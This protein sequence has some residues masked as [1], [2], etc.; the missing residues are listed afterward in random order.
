MNVPSSCRRFRRCGLPG[1]CGFG[2]LIAVLLCI[3]AVCHAL[4]QSPPFDFDKIVFITR[5][6]C[7]SNHY[8]TD[9][10]NGGFFPEGNLCVL[11]LKT[12]KVGEIV[13]R[14]TGGMFGRFDLSFDATKVVF[15]WKK[16]V[17]EGYRIYEC[18]IDGGHLHQLTVPPPEEPALIAR[19]RRGYHHGTDDMDPCYLPD[20]GI[21][22]IST[23]CQYGI[24]CDGP[25]IF[26][27]T[28]LYRMD[29]NG[30]NLE[31]LTN[32]SVSEATPAVTNDGRIL[33]TRWEYVDK[34]AVSVKCLWA[35]NPDGT[36]S[37]EI[38][39]A[40]IALPPT[41][42]QGRPIPG[43]NNLFVVMGT[44]HCPQNAVGTVIR[45]DAS[46]NT[47]TREPMTYMTPDVDVRAEG[48]FWFDAASKWGPRLFKDPYPLSESRFL[49][50]LNPSGNALE[51]TNWGLYA[52]DESGNATVIYRDERTGCFM[53]IPLRPRT[54][55]PVLPSGRDPELAAKNLAACLVQDVYQGMDGIQ[56]GQAKYLRINEQAPRP[57]S[58]RRTWDERAYDQQH[59]CISKDAS[60]GLKVQHG[61]VP[62]EA[63]GSA[64]F[65]VPA[66]KN[67]YFQVLDA[68]FME[69]QRERTYVNYRPGERRSC[70]GCHE[71]P[72]RVP[73]Q[74]NGVR[75]ALKRSP[76]LP[77]PQPGE[78]TGA[79]P[80]HYPTDV[81]PVW[82]KHCIECHSGKTPKGNLDLSGEITEW[83]NKSYESLMPERRKLPLHDP[84]LLGIIIGENHP[85]TGNVKYLPPKSL[86]SHTSVLVAM[87][88]GGSVQ[89]TNPADAVRA[90][91]LA[92]KHKQIKLTPEELVRITTW[93]EANGQYYGSYYGKR[94]SKFTGDPDFRPVP[95]FQEATRQR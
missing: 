32:S 75:L 82:D 6:N 88:S 1:R 28:V 94:L 10:I 64:Y 76:S 95:T 12:G 48:G 21:C 55:P 42:T 58:A 46:K 24:L 18:A 8:Y 86:G 27:T 35:M 93:I 92:E 65:L 80:L 17:D 43:K 87:L 51:K 26:T 73:P 4:A 74:Q 61:I 22:F 85:K 31:K 56:R 45:I 84:R 9:Y 23:R 72:N 89:L 36:G 70:V 53:P 33:Y 13:K 29:A 78:T 90:T 2:T 71:T 60:L 20:G 68:N 44:P 7:Q 37:T 77:G 50:S 38:Y 81:Q 52:L 41:L 59:A 63:D 3:T 66:D 16:N 67:I 19:Y 40:D 49:V 15:A 54:K 30:G 79:R 14:L 57:W 69:L 91:S 83:F 11:D 5:I 25:D 47:R 62:I 39:G 34:G